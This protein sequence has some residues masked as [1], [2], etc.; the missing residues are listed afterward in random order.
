MTPGALMSVM[1]QPITSEVKLSRRWV[2]SRSTGKVW[3]VLLR[4]PGS[5]YYRLRRHVA[6]RGRTYTYLRRSI[7]DLQAGWELLDEDGD[8]RA[9]GMR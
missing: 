3:F 2:R 6:G 5:N 7:E 1:A 8:G 9:A 4:H